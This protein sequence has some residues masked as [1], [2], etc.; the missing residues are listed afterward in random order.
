MKCEACK[1]EYTATYNEDGK[2]FLIGDREFE[3]IDNSFFVKINNN[4]LYKTIWICPKC[5]TLK[6]EL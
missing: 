6:I 4:Y 3:C 2:E 1:Y 5:G